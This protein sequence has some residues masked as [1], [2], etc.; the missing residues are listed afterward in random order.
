MHISL[1]YHWNI[2]IIGISWKGNIIGNIEIFKAK[3]QPLH[4]YL[5]FFSGFPGPKSSQF[6]Q[7]SRPLKTSLQ[8]VVSRYTTSNAGLSCCELKTTWETTAVT[9]N[10]FSL[11]WKKGGLTNSSL[12]WNT[13]WCFQLSFNWSEKYAHQ[14]GSSPLRVPRIMSLYSS[15]L[16]G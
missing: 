16:I 15:Y 7:L 12:W 4:S 6:P 5:A 9:R 13:S 8:L 11:W 2:N 3:F 14:I 10:P 1:E